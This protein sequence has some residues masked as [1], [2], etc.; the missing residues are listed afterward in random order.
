MTSESSTT[1]QA[2]EPELETIRD[3]CH[4]IAVSQAEMYRLLGRGKVE[5]VKAGKRTLLKVSSLKAHAASLPPAK[6]KPPT[7]RRRLGA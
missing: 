2:L 6:I 4:R 5:G 7:R 3:G 1:A